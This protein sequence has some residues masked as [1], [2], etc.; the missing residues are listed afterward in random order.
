MI[1][2]GWL[3]GMRKE[4]RD[5]KECIKSGRDKTRTKR[6]EKERVLLE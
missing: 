2:S 3:G 6:C 5:I 1:P 4:E